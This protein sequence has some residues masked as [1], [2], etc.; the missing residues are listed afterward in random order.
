MYQGS[1]T[2][3][4]DPQ[5]GSTNAAD[6]Q[7]TLE[8]V[9][10]PYQVGSHCCRHFH[11]GASGPAYRERQLELSD[12]LLTEL[13]RRESPH[14]LSPSFCLNFYQLPPPPPP[15]PPPTPPPPPEEEEDKVEAEEL[16][17]LLKLDPK[18]VALK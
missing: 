17:K 14:G 7:R 15:P 13:K 4:P 3:N 11:A 18:E 8:G 12:E 10:L 2:F 6:L 1:N 9:T 16:L 5:K